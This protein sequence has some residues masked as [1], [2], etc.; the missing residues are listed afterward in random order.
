MKEAL[1]HKNT[2][3]NWSNPVFHVELPVPGELARIELF[4]LSSLDF[5]KFFRITSSLLPGPCT[6]PPPP[7][8]PQLPPPHPISTPPPHCLSK[9]RKER[10]VEW[11]I[12]EL[13]TSKWGGYILET[14]ASITTFSLLSNIEVCRADSAPYLNL[15]AVP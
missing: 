7:P 11:M 8:A 14:A 3:S 12:W 2:E 10:T 4:Q 1:D 6:A 15:A 13:Q 9:K 5:F